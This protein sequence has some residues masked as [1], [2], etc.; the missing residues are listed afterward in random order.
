[1][2]N[3]IWPDRRAE[4]I[5]SA[6]EGPAVITKKVAI[7]T[8]MKMAGITPLGVIFPK[9][10][11][12]SLLWICAGQ[13]R[14]GCQLSSQFQRSYKVKISFWTVV[15]A[16]YTSSILFIICSMYKKKKSNLPLLYNKYIYKIPA[17]CCGGSYSNAREGPHREGSHC[18]GSPNRDRPSRDGNPRGKDAPYHKFNPHYS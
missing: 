15:F 18:S 9:V 8:V 5:S 4:G 11:E 16:D 13:V 14:L 17:S 1:M 10:N 6:V 2:E 3:S 7:I 12:G